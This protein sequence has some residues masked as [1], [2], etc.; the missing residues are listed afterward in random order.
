MRNGNQLDC[1]YW[2]QYQKPFLPYLWGMETTTDEMDC[3]RALTVLTV[4]MRNGNYRACWTKSK[5]LSSYRTYEEWKHHKRVRWY[6][7]SVSSYRTY[8]EWKRE[9]SIEKYRDRFPVL[10]VPMR[11]GNLTALTSHS[12]RVTIVLTVPMRNGN[13]VV[14]V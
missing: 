1:R 14:A 10:T 8:E 9:E 6:N 11:N 7:S 13:Q 4:P 3:Y 12:L 5:H 2:V